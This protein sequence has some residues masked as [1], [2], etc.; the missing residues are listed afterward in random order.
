MMTDNRAPAPPV[1]KALF[2][3]M[4]K[5]AANKNSENVEMKPYELIQKIPSVI[6]AIVNPLFELSDN[7]E[8]SEEQFSSVIGVRMQ[9]A[10]LV[11]HSNYLR[12]C[13]SLDRLWT[14]FGQ[15]F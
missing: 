6:E 14:H 4:T 7:D 5:D 2:P 11:W 9:M 12:S 1:L 10:L 15:E 3:D 8:V 13:T